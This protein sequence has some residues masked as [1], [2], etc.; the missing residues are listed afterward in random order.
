[1]DSPNEEVL[2]CELEI[3]AKDAQRMWSDITYFKRYSLWAIFNI[4]TDEDIDWNKWSKD[5]KI[6]WEKECEEFKK[7]SI[8]KPRDKVMQQILKIKKE[9]EISKDIGEHIDLFLKDLK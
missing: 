8:W 2:S 5:K 7:R 1:M 9:Y 3:T 6:F 4:I